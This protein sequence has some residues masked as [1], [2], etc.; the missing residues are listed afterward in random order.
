MKFDVKPNITKRL[1]FMQNSWLNNTIDRLIKNDYFQ[2][3]LIDCVLQ[4]PFKNDYF[5]PYR[6]L[7]LMGMKKAGGH[8]FLRELRRPFVWSDIAW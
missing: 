6:L 7:R 4:P 1:N 5:G 2:L 8:A 3:R